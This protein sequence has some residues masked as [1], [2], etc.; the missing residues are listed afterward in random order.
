M[1][2]PYQHARLCTEPIVFPLLLSG[3]TTLTA[4]H[5]INSGT[6]RG[7]APASASCPLRCPLVEQR[8]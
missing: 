2:F 4:S 6:M 7:F 1:A 5:R 3:V 8:L